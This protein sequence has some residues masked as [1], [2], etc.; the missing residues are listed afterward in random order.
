MQESPA[1]KQIKRIS[2]LSVLIVIDNE[3]MIN[4]II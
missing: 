4:F 3:L 1:V 2:F